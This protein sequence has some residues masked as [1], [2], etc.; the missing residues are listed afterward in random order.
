MTRFCSSLRSVF[1]IAGPVLANGLS[2]TMSMWADT[3]DTLVG[4][5]SEGDSCKFA[6][7]EMGGLSAPTAQTPYIISKHYCAVNH[8]MFRAGSICG[9][10]YRITYAGDQPQG[11]GRLGSLVVQVVDSGAWATFDCHMSA[12]ET[13]TGASTNTFS[14]AYEPVPCATS[15]EGAVAAVLSYDYYWTKFV[16]SDMKYPVESAEITVGDKSYEMNRVLRNEQGLRVLGY[17]AVWTGPVEGKVSFTL[18][19]GHG[20]NA[21]LQNCFSGWANR[22]PG[23]SCSASSSAAELLA[24]PGDGALEWV[25]AAVPPVPT[26][27]GVPDVVEYL[28]VA[29]NPVVPVPVVALLASGGNATNLRGAIPLPSTTMDTEIFP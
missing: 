26:V 7:K 4:Y 27:P 9:A 14:I 20:N 17:W 22:K 25:P 15:S 21:V 6:D 18:V 13:I 29:P 1:V 23:S 2:G 11:L 8:E 24:G 16:F 5:K 3:E 10:C 19:D 12:F 28:P